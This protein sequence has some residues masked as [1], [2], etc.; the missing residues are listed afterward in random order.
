MG[1]EILQIHGLMQREDA[2]LATSIFNAQSKSQ[3]L[4]TQK[5][6]RKQQC[7]FV[8]KEG[9]VKKRMNVRMR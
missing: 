4:D 6:R 5:K 9:I 7:L 2:G 3:V 8:T 1:I